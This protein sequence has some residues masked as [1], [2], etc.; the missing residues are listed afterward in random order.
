MG[1]LEAKYEKLE[2]R[3]HKLEDENISKD[4]AQA[5]VMG[6]FS[7]QIKIEKNIECYEFQDT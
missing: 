6:E 7:E 3:V 1:N 5:M 4:S 2:E